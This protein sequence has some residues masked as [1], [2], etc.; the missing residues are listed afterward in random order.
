MKI[1]IMLP[2][3]A[4]FYLCM[5]CA[6]NAC[7]AS[8]GA[9]KKQGKS[10]DQEKIVSTDIQNKDQKKQVS[11]GTVLTCINNE[12]LFFS[13]Q[14]DNRDFSLCAI[15]DNKLL[16]QEHKNGELQKSFQ[17]LPKKDFMYENYTRYMV[18]NDVVTFSSKNTV[19]EIYE[20]HGEEKQGEIH[21][22]GIS[23]TQPNN[24]TEKIICKKV[25]SN[26]YKAFEE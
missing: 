6:L 3:K 19:Y 24:K 4:A 7:A 21:E 22:Y 10:K 20:Y 17:G 1:I 14:V 26:L 18:S 15:G 2:K 5:F 11:E 23:I 25:K 9:Q 8:S 16:F 12:K 13:C